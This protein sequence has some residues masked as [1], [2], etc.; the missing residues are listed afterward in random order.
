MTRIASFII[1]LAVA[2]V[3]GYCG[4]KNRGFHDLLKFFGIE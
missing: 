2:I 4:G 1:I 3:F